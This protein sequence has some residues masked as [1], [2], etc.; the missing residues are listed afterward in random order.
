MVWNR[1][2]FEGTPTDELRSFQTTRAMRAVLGIAP[3]ARFLGGF[4]AFV[5]GPIPDAG[6]ARALR[7]VVEPMSGPPEPFTAPRSESVDRAWERVRTCMAA[8]APE[9][10]G[11]LGSPALAEDVAHVEERLG[12]KLPDELRAWLAKHDGQRSS[13]GPFEWP[14]ETL[15]QAMST[16]TMLDGM[17]PE[18]D[19]YELP[20]R[21]DDGVLARWWHDRWFPIAGDGAG[22][23]LS[24]DLDPAPGGIVGQVIEYR[25][26]DGAR[27]L[28]APSLSAWFDL[29]A[30]RIESGALV[31]LEYHDGSFLSL[32]PRAL[33]TGPLA[34]AKLRGEAAEARR[35]RIEGYYANRPEDLVMR[36]LDVLRKRDAIAL[37]DGTDWFLSCLDASR[38]GG[39]VEILRALR[40]T[41]AT[42]S[43]TPSELAAAMEAVRRGESV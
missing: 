41:G 35:A 1:L 39:P 26:D 7:V 23:H 32:T 12:M 28:V 20:I 9:A 5:D 18:F 29:T 17:I 36:A 15:V 16:K 38:A 11:V 34:G 10:L 19:G 21:A 33:V 6:A 40:A 43:V 24:I 27:P 30:D 4:A 25:H 14:L 31:A 42:T 37:A 13:T 3:T 22:N 8:I 2:R